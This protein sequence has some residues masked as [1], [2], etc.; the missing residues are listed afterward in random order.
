M[1]LMLAPAANMTF[2]SLPSGSTYVS[3]ANGLIVIANNSVP[4]QTA[5]EAAGCLT[6]NT[7]L[8]AFPV[9]AATL[10]ALYT[11][12]T[13]NAYPEGTTAQVFNDGGNTGTWLKTGTGTGSGNWTQESTSTFASLAAGLASEIATR[14]AAVSTE[15]ARAEAAESANAAAI[16]AETARAESAEAIA[17][18]NIA[19]LMASLATLQQQLTAALFNTARFC[20]GGTPPGTVDAAT[21]GALPSS[22]Y[23]DEPGG[24]R[25]IGLGT[26]ALPA[27]DGVSMTVGKRLLVK[28]QTAALQNGIFV[29]TQQGDGTNPWILTR[30]PDAYQAGQ[31]GGIECVVNTGGNTLAGSVWML[32][33]AAGAILVGTTALNF[34]QLD[35]P[36]NFLLGGPSRWDTVTAGSYT[37]GAQSKNIAA[38]PSSG[39]VNLTLPATHQSIRVKDKTGAASP[40]KPISIYPDPGSTIEGGAGPFVMNVGRQGFSLEFDTQNSDWSIFG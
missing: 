21:T 15:T 17:S 30:A 19:A 38:D 7:L 9:G 24:D 39:A 1:I 37:L 13:T 22:I 26:S 20:A 8:S 14:A 12:D 6:L 10:S 16:T 3:D 31:L 33:I 2:A 5:M 4:D 36:G 29:L 27:Q 18:I 25:L 28:N 32:P 11:L 34:V 35:A 40:A 23:D